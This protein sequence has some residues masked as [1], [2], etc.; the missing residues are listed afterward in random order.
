MNSE[1]MY[2]KA[3]ASSER[4]VFKKLR[5][6]EALAKNVRQAKSQ[7]NEHMSQ[8]LRTQ[9]NTILGFAQI[10]DR[11]S[12]DTT[13]GEERESIASILTASR[14][15]QHCIDSLLGLAA[16]EIGDPEDA[17]SDRSPS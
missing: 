14:S 10:L 11:C 16:I 1:K 4:K 2:S 8:E 12:D 9:L 17:L 7:L 13:F 6:K 15:L 5:G 3:Q